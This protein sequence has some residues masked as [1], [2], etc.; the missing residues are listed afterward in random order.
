MLRSG[1]LQAIFGDGTSFGD[2]TLIA[3]GC[4]SSCKGETFCNHYASFLDRLMSTYSGRR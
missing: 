3:L 4:I 1:D 2:S